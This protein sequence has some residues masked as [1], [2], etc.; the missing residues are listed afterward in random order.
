MNVAGRNVVLAAI[1]TAVGGVLAI[2]GAFLVW[3]TEK[4][5]PMTV[6]VKGM[7]E[8]DMNGGTVELVLGI[9][10]LALVAAWILRIKIPAIPLLLAVA[11][12]LILAV[13]AAVYFTTILSKV[14][15]KDLTDQVKAVGGTID[16]GIGVLLEIMAGIVVIVGGA[17]GFMRKSA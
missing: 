1:V 8:K 3:I 4:V 14:S 6:D 15:L 7:G 13:I 10:V 12:V 5:G 16:L 11:G 17:L 9:V 2:V